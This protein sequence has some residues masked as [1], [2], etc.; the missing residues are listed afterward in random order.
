M[1]GMFTRLAAAVLSQRQLSK[2]FWPVGPF[3]PSL[4]KYVLPGF[5]AK[6]CLSFA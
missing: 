4:V 1:Y 3:N 5:G 2:G 6:G